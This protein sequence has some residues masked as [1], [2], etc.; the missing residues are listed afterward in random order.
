MAD[1]KDDGQKFKVTRR[2]L[3]GKAPACLGGIGALTMLFR[4]DPRN[5]PGCP[6]DCTLEC[7]DTCMELCTKDVTNH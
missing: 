1:K 7:Q 3:L 5:P 6:S 4:A 2:S